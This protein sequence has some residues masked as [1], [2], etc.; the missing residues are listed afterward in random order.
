[1]VRQS[2]FPAAV[3]SLPAW[4]ILFA[5][6]PEEDMD[7]DELDDE[8]KTETDDTGSQPDEPEKPS[9]SRPLILALL[10]V[11]AV[12]GGYLAMNPDLVM[13]MMGQET[14]GEPQAPAPTVP[15]KPAAAP[16]ASPGAT[17][18]PAPPASPKPATAPPEPASPQAKPVLPAAPAA[19]AAPPVQ[20][21]KA[22][23]V[24]AVPTT[25]IAPAPAASV[26]TPL[27]SEG[28]LVTVVPDSMLPAAAVSL[29][30]D[31]GRTRPGPLVS[32]TAVLTV[33]DG[34]F[35][36]NSWVYAVRTPQGTMGWIAEKQLKAAKR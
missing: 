9:R 12:G 1:M 30:S 7:L 25:P 26:S 16:P 31:A 10:A 4:S 28:Q 11:V 23:P 35:R 21:A 22:T 5:R 33:V 8:S 14:E 24:P 27:F 17:A 13:D 15:A 3:S 20:T 36:G 34:E 6:E 2:G 29:S 32:P 19:P 18:A